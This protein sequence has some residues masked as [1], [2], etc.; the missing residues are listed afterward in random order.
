MPHLRRIGIEFVLLD[1]EEELV[2]KL[3]L[4]HPPAEL[5][6]SGQVNRPQPSRTQSGTSIRNNGYIWSEFRQGLFDARWFSIGGA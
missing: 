5:N 3:K 1:S 4:A 6:Q 2:S